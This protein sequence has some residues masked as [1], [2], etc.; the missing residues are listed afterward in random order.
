MMSGSGSAIP[1]TR[2]QRSTYHVATYAVTPDLRPSLQRAADG[3]RPL[4]GKQPM[5]ESSRPSLVPS[6]AKRSCPKPSML[7][8]TLWRFA[9]ERQRVYLRRVAGEPY[10]WTNDSVLSRYRFTNA[11][12]AADRVSQH[13]IR[14]TYSERD[15]SDDTM[16]LRTILFK[17][18]NKIEKRGN[19]SSVTWACLTPATLT[20]HGAT[21]CSPSGACAT[22][23]FTQ[24]RTSCRLETGRTEAS[25][26]SAPDT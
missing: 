8:S 4:P 26:A 12:R 18:F 20:T 16:F 21:S 7:Y 6:F 23:R 11:Y 5:N 25:D 14:M 15:A 10:P 19:P 9:S 22:R 3:Q 1:V 2:R 17:V 13:L 24:R